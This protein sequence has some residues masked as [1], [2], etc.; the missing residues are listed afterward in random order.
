MVRQ[1][2][3]TRFGKVGGAAEGHGD[4]T[5]SDPRREGSSSRLGTDEPRR[6]RLASCDCVNPPPRTC[7]HQPT[8]NSRRHF[9]QRYLPCTGTEI[10]LW[11][12]RQYESP[13]F[14]ANWFHIDI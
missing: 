12:R 5:P 13:I 9:Q 10:E 2:A 8:L 1:V 3:L 6:L 11:N 4:M 7:S 14:L